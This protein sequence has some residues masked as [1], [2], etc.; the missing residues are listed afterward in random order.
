VK[1]DEYGNNNTIDSYT[2]SVDAGGTPPPDH[3]PNNTP[4]SANT[5]GTDGSP[6]THSIHMGSDVDWVKFTLSETSDV[7]I[8]T[9]GS[10]GDTRMW[11]YGPDSSSNQ[12]AYND[13]GGS[14]Y[15][16]RISRTALAAG[17]YYVKVDEYGNNNTI[18]S[19]TI[20]VTELMV[21]DVFLVQG[22]SPIST[23]IRTG[24]A[25]ELGVPYSS[26]YSHAAIYAGSG[27]VSEMLSGGYEET[28]LE[29]WF[30]RNDDVDIYRHEQIGGYGNAVAAAVRDHAD[31]PYALSQ[32]DVLAV[33]AS[34]PGIV[35]PI[36][37]SPGWASYLLF[38]V[39]DQRMICSELVARVFAEAD[40]SL[41]LS[42]DLWPTLDL[43]GDISENFRWDFTTPTVL[44][45]SP[46]LRQLDA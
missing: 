26:T 10:S 4:A 15:F 35:G 3:E 46:S 27:T 6:Q 31:T 33:T 2:I 11:L 32:I 25:L 45:R 40:D 19:Y 20:S 41:G 29:A 16:S 28:T 44:S 37:A 23:A 18:D 43:I 38:D 1:V 13:D 24:E 36:L 7:L 12:I 39:G 14:G 21:G 34:S 30:G 42:V 17:T 8:E 9:A 22:D 5:I